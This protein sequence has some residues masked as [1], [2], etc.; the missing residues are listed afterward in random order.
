IQ[1]AKMGGRTIQTPEGAFL[2]A[3]V[4]GQKVCIGY[5]DRNSILKKTDFIK[6]N[7]FAG[8]FTWTI[9]FDGPG[10]SV[11]NAIKD[12]L[13]G[14]SVAPPP[15]SSGTTRR[16]P[17]PVPAATTKKTNPAPA[18]APAP[19][20]GKCTDGTMRA[21]ANKAKYDQCLWGS[22]QTRDCPP[23]TVFD[24]ATNNFKTA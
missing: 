2:E 8:A 7:G 22:W 14:G 16:V 4:N 12:G 19:S 11:H 6:K 15:A 10:F 3:K 18:P 21:N 17:V 24:P 23:G 5:D 13:S 9:D 1:I 20:G